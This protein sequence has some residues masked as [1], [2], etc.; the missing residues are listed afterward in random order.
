MGIDTAEPCLYSSSAFWIHT[1]VLDVD[2]YLIVLLA[3]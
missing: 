3:L 2:G 1:F